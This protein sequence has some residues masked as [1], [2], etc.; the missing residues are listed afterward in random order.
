MLIS[1]KE[2]AM[3]KQAKRLL[4]DASERRKTAT[5]LIEGARL[6]EDAALT[7]IHIKTAF[8][9]Q[10]GETKY[11]EQVS[12]IKQSAEEVFEITDTVSAAI[13]DTKNPQGV[14]CICRL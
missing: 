10:A 7:G 4:S 9:T 5:F 3:V 12:A 11:P 8:F 2:N 13:S 14:F 6:C 1:S